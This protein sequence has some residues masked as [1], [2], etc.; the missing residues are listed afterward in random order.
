MKIG[1]LPSIPN[2]QRIL[3]GVMSICI[4]LSLFG[5][6]SQNPSIGDSPGG[7]DGATDQPTS[8]EI[9]DTMQKLIHQNQLQAE[10]IADL[11]HEKQEAEFEAAVANNKE[12]LIPQLTTMLRT[13]APDGLMNTF[14]FQGTVL[15]YDIINIGYKTNTLFV[16]QELLWKLGDGSGEVAV[17][18]TGLDIETE[19]VVFLDLRETKLISAK[20]LAKAMETPS[21]EEAIAVPERSVNATSTPRSDGN[22]VNWKPDNQ[23]VN[24][25]YQTG[26][27]LVGAGLLLWLQHLATQDN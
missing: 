7:Q 24:K 12:Y 11:K 6:A 3:A 16:T 5:C 15:D 9:A 19:N 8:L 25:A 2:P 17:I 14:N 18:D 23:T 22:N 13:N 27:G 1:R 10:Q 21:T 20:D 4:S 26:I